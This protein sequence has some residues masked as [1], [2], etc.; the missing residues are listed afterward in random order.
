MGKF[1]KL[2]GE[3]V[4]KLTSK[5]QVFLSKAIRERVGLVPGG[6]VSIRANDQGEVVLRAVPA[7]VETPIQRSA[8]IRQALENATGII[9]LGGLT[10]DEY[11]RELRG[12]FEP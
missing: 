8:R 6:A 2:E 7:R 1:E 9:D 11:M 4:V 12:D 3:T 10:T 5:G